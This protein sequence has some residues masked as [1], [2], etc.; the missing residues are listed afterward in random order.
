MKLNRNPAIAAGRAKS[1]LRPDEVLSVG[2]SEEGFSLRM[3]VG[4]CTTLGDE[5]QMWAAVLDRVR[6]VAVEK[7]AAATGAPAE[8]IS[9]ALYLELNHLAGVA[10]EE[11]DAREVCEHF[12]LASHPETK[13]E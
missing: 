13:E 6:H 11:F 5:I 7:M 1:G 4:G 9:E 12:G 8:R 10:N 3:G 2:V